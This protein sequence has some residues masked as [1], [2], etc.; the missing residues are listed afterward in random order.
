MQPGS[1]LRECSRQNLQAPSPHDALHF[2]RD[3]EQLGR[4][5]VLTRRERGGRE[6]S[7]AYFLLSLTCL[8]VTKIILQVENFELTQGEKRVPANGKVGFVVRHVDDAMSES[9]GNFSKPAKPTPSR[10]P[11]A[12]SWSRICRDEHL[13]RILSLSRRICMVVKLT[14]QILAA[15]SPYAPPPPP[16]FRS[17]FSA[18]V[19]RL[20]TL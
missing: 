1:L 18:Y 9:S 15:S 5:R 13:C 19:L 10:L 17:F 14:K 20:V 12:A 4:R 3:F 7:S 6:G 8:G 2:M 11:P 16:L